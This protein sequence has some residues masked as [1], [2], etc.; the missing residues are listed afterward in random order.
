MASG[1]FSAQIDAFVRETE[2]R[3]T[4][5]FRESSQ[6]VMSRATEFIS[7]QLVNVDTG[8]LRASV[9]V[10]FSEMPKIDSA[11]QPKDGQSYPLSG[12]VSL[13]IASAHLGDTIHAGYTAAYAGFVHAVTSKMAGRPWVQLAAMQWPTIV[14]GV[15][16]ELKGRLGL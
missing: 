6:R 10:S 7:G 15:T 5:V 8:F 4:A 2:Q 3:M 12:E 9:R 11:A 14:N 1:S 16:Q 13:M